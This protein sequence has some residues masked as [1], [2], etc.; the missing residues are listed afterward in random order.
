M[1]FNMYHGCIAVMNLDKT[2]EFYNKALGLKVIKR[3]DD[4]GHFRLAY[5]GTEGCQCQL[6]VI[7]NTGKTEPYDLGDNEI[8]MGFMTDD[9]D[10]SIKLHKEMGCFHHENSKY[11]L[12]F[13]EDPDG[14][15]ME[16]LG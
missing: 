3:I 2:I 15:M 9:Y 8:H 14:Y 13:I 7:E 11:K 6:E 16:I 10:K 5:L 12:Y 1:K 4:K